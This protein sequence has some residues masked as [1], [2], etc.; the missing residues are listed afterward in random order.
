TPNH[1][2]SGYVCA[3]V[4]LPLLRRR[5][6]VSPRA[7][8]VAITL[9]A[10]VPDLDILSRVIVGRAAYFSGL[11]YA[12]R[13]V[14]HSIVGTLLLALILAALL[15]RPLV[16]RDTPRPWT[17]FAW[18]AGFAWAGGLLHIFGDLFTPG[19][20]MPVFWPLAVRFGGWRHIGWFSPYLLWLFVTAI[21]LGVLME[22]GLGRLASLRRWVPAM[23]WGMYALAVFRWVDFL[24]VSHY[25]GWSE[26]LAYQQQLLPDAMILPFTEGVHAIW[27]WFTG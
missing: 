27:H 6:P 10:M 1:G 8:G 22:R 25:S 3:Q 21:A 17:A 13:G 16:P 24:S 4:A 11:W 5:S 9:G 23:V 14:S 2:L 15:Y 20:Q 7:L 18:L 19:W 12:H 26:W